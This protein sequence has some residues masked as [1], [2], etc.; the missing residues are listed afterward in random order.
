M[1]KKLNIRQNYKLLQPYLWKEKKLLLFG[2]LLMIFV[3]LTHLIDP[4]ILA[5]IV[6]VS[7]PNKDLNDMYRYAFFFI[8]LIFVSG[9]ASYTQIIILSKLGLKVITDI[10]MKLFS[11]LMK[12]SV[13]FFDNRPV[14]DFITKVENDSEK[15]RFL[16][17]EL[18]IRI[19]GNLLFFVGVIIVITYKSPDVSV[20]I[21]LTITIIAIAYNYF[22]RFM[23]KIFKRVREKYSEVTAKINEYVQGMHVIQTF[24]KEDEAISIVEKT[25]AEKKLIETKA[26]FLEYSVEGF[27]LFLIEYFMFILVIVLIVPQIFDGTKSIGT[28]I[29]FSQYINRIIWPLIQLLENVMQI[30]KSMV[31]LTRIRE[32][33]ELPVEDYYNNKLEIKSFEEEIEFKNVW[34]A[35]EAENW[36]LKDVSFKVR[37]GE[38]V[39]LVG[40]SGSGKTTTISLICG[41]YKYQKGEILIDGIPLNK[42][43][44]KKWRRKVGLILQDVL[45]F[46]GNVIENVRIY[47]DSI[48]AEQVMESIKMVHAEKFFEMGSLQNIIAERGQNIS[49]GEKQLLSFARALTFNPEIVIMDEATSSIDTVTERKIQ[50]SM[51]KVLAGK[52]A[53]IVAHRLSSIIDA[54]NIIYFKDG[55]IKNQGTHT[56]L[57]TTSP[58]YQNLV[59]LQFMG[60]HDE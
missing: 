40:P 38:K 13:S 46:P 29:I 20:W 8:G 39:A 17:S 9:I 26:S 5:H 2:L 53:M 60:G 15:V 59:N 25:S 6:D 3:S 33:S 23:G 4:L 10:K 18:S 28:L 50:D 24:H 34:F 52:T 32:L 7:V 47:D 51:L 19:I 54:D 48:S 42:L 31:S 1:S 12:I 45:L 41:F 56:Q 30:Q 49:Q 21:L 27:F 57:M 36:I 14:G 11:H 44:I 22:M 37:K 16:F 35:Y 43:N 55:Q 58:D